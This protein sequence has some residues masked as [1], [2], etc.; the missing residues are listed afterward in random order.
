MK[1]ALAQI[2]SIPGDVQ[3]NIDN[4]IR[5]IDLAF[6]KKADLIIFPELSLTAY[7][8]E[9]S[10]ELSIKIDDN[11]LKVFDNLSTQYNMLIG[12]GAPLRQE[13]GVSIS[14]LF[15]HPSEGRQVYSKQMLHEDEKAFFIERKDMTII[16][17]KDQRIAPAICYEALQEDHLRKAMDSKAVLY[18]ASVAKHEDG[19]NEAVEYFNRMYRKYSV[20]IAMVNAIGPNDGFIS[21]GGSSVWHKEKGLISQMNYEEECLMSLDL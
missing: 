14:T 1:V 6:A 11:R 20:S 10:K 12:L 8:P 3:K 13:E 9:L 19:V 7:E 18:L 4:H 5:W 17:F 21:S 16:D 2:R 15:F